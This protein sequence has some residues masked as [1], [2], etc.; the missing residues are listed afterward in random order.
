[1]RTLIRALKNLRSSNVHVTVKSLVEE[2]GLNLQ[3][4]S[5]NIFSLS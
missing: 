4:A 2:S 5:R 3:L 1:M